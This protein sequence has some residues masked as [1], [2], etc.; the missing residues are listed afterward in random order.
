[1]PS[2]LLQSGWRIFFYSNEGNEPIHVHCMKGDIECKFWIDAQNFD[3]QEAYAF[4]L[5]PPDRKMVRR[6][7]FEHF[8]YIV[9]KWNEFQ[10]RKL[11]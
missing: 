10:E 3:I 8:E 4:N 1:M 9:D 11:P 6:I 5:S 2:I 7:I